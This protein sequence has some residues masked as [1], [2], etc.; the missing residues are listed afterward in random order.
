MGSGGI[1]RAI[2]GEINFGQLYELFQGGDLPQIRGRPRLRTRRT[3][4]P[5]GSGFVVR[6]A[7]R[8]SSAL[9]SPFPETCSCS[10]CSPVGL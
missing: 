6:S 3:S 5:S 9:R 7:L 1:W 2:W 8:P 10:S 4:R